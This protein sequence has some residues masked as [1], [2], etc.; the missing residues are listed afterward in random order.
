MAVTLA[1][2]AAGHPGGLARQQQHNSGPPDETLRE[3]L[4]VRC[5]DCFQ[6]LVQRCRLKAEGF[7]REGKS[8]LY[9]A[10]QHGNDHL[11]DYIIH[12]MEVSSLWNPYIY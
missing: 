11:A 6:L 1:T 12:R 5:L 7:D 2:A 8:F 4:R 3:I 10:L 9:M